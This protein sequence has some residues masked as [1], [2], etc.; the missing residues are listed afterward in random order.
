MRA[1]DVM[2]RHAWTVSPDTSILDA[3]SLMVKHNVSGLPVINDDGEVVGIVTESDFLRPVGPV[4]GRRRWLEVL[5]KP[6]LTTPERLWAHATR[7]KDIMTTDPIS[8]SE[9]TSLEEA[10]RLMGEHDVKRLVVTSGRKLVGVVS[11]ADLLRALPKALGAA[12]LGQ[13]EHQQE[14]RRMADLERQLW[15]RRL[16]P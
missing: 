3:A 1:G 4:A 5:M 13:R 9:D 6:G 15:M 10:V 12:A 8:I 2:T 7:V 14:R 16:H 11:R